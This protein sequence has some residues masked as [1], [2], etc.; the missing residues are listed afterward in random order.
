MNGKKYPHHLRTTK[1]TLYPANRQLAE[2]EIGNW[3]II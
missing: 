2:I 1:L 3:T